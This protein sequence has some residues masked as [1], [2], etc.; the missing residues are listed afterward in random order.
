MRVPNS[1]WCSSRPRLPSGF[2]RL[3]S[4]PA[5]KPSS[6]IEKPATRTFVMANAFHIGHLSDCRQRV[7]YWVMNGRGDN[8]A[9]AAA[10]PPITDSKADDWRGGSGPIADSLSA[11]YPSASQC[12]VTNAVPGQKPTFAF[13]FDYFVGTQQSEVGAVGLIY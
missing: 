9:G 11:K 3:C 13:S 4:G 8:T 10:R 2:S 6:E 5:P 1:N 7:R 12:R